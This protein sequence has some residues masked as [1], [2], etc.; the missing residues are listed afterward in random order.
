[1]GLDLNWTDVQA[2][3]TGLKASGF[4]EADLIQLAERSER[5]Q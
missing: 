2:K 4:T 3:L 5:G 1:M